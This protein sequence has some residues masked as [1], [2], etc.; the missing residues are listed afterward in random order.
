MSEHQR[1]N[2]SSPEKVIWQAEGNNRTAMR[3]EHTIRMARSTS[4]LFSNTKEMVASRESSVTLF[5]SRHIVDLECSFSHCDK[6]LLLLH[7][8][9]SLHLFQSYR[10]LIRQL[11]TSAGSTA[12]SVVLC[13][14]KTLRA[15]SCRKYTSTM[16]SENAT[17]PDMES[18]V[19]DYNTMKNL[20]R[21]N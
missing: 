14:T 8:S 12:S 21:P 11:W 19:S 15:Q 16:A 13:S 4:I 20:S 1:R 2:R 5:D 9:Y 17:A 7:I 3:E 18:D 6:A 10:F